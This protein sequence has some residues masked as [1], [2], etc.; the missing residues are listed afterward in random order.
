MRGKNN[1]T[2]TAWRSV[3]DSSNVAS[4]ALPIGGGTLTGAING[5]TASFS[6]NVKGGRITLR[7]DCLEQHVDDSDSVGVFVN[8]FGFAS[9]TTR[10]RNF[11]VFNGKNQQLF[12]IAGS[13]GAVAITGTL[14]VTGAIT[15]GGNQVLHA[16]N[17]TTYLNNT[18]L[19]AAK[20]IKI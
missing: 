18:Y 20:P 11:G 4:Y 19:R 5:T 8:Y 16:G 15:Q 9:G 12:Y 6:G 10:F 7:D 2:W 13:T 17:Y 3:L 1:G 14:G